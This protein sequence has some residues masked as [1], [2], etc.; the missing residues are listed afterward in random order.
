MALK[1]MFSAMKKVRGFPSYYVTKDGHVYSEKYGDLR[2]LKPITDKYGYLTVHLYKNNKMYT[3]YVH[4]LVAK[5]Y[6]PNPNNYKLVN[7][8]DECVFNNY[9]TNL[10]WCDQ[11]YNLNYG[12]ARKRMALSKS[13]TVY[14]YSLDDVFIKEWSSSYEIERELGIHNT[15]I[16]KCVNGKKKTTHGYR[17]SYERLEDKDNVS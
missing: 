9:Y 10:E 13:K 1:D 2:E 11:L 14:Q 16:N 4:Q 8:K 3:R 6:I 15:L 12:T 5:A 7:H 17:W